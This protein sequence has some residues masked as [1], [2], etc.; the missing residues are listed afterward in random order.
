MGSDNE[1]KQ[2]AADGVGFA[3]EPAVTVFATIDV[4][5]GKCNEA[6]FG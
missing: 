5:G 2:S 4:V 1:R 6:A 3:V